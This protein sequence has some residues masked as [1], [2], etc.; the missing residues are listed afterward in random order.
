[1]FFYPDSTEVEIVESNGIK[2]IEIP[3]NIYFEIL[4]DGDLVVYGPAT[5]KR[6]VAIPDVIHFGKSDQQGVVISEMGLIWP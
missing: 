5:E 3:H 2:H 4:R 6:T 1:M